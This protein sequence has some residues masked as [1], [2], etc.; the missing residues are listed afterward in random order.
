LD[1]PGEFFESLKNKGIKATFQYEISGKV[2][3]LGF[4]VT[5]GSEKVYLNGELLKRDTDYSIDY[6]TGALLIF[7]E[8]G[9]DDKVRVDFERARGGFG[10]F[11]EYGRNLY[12]FSTR[13]ESDYGLVMDVSLFQARDS[14]PEKIP[15]E[16]STMPN[17]HTVAGI[18]TKYQENGWDVGLKFAGNVNRFPFDDNKRIN[19]PNKINE[20]ISLSDQGYDMT[21]FLHNNGFTARESDN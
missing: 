17:V 10:G 7:K 14:A 3:M 8:L 1:F 12:G 18:A 21:L 19:L 15:P 4:S 20:I 6:E 11:A 9:P 13:M 5:P 2:Y 16:A